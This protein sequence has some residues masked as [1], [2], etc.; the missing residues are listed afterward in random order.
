MYELR[1]LRRSLWN[2][3]GTPGTPVWVFRGPRRRSLHSGRILKD[4][5]RVERG[6][7]AK[8]CETHVLHP[9]EVL[10]GN[11]KRQFHVFR[12]EEVRHVR[13]VTG[14]KTGTVNITRRIKIVRAVY[15][16]NRNKPGTPLR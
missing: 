8:T 5:K 6:A 16:Q 10:T 9:P 15:L 7:G 11:Q 4:D 1:V 3:V 13:A 14:V 2:A 12:R